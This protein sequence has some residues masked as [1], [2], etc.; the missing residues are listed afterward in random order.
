MLWNREKGYKGIIVL[1][2]IILLEGV[3]LWAGYHNRLGKAESI[4]ETIWSA[5]VGA[6]DG[7]IVLNEDQAGITQR[8]INQHEDL[9]TIYLF[10][11]HCQ[12][13]DSG[14]ITVKLRDAVNVTY[15]ETVFNLKDYE[16]DV[17]C[18]VMSPEEQ[19][20]FKINEEYFIEIY[21]KDLQGKYIEVGAVTDPSKPEVFD[22]FE[23]GTALF[24]GLEYNYPDLTDSRNWIHKG[25]IW[26]VILDGFLLGVELWNLGKKKYLVGYVLVLVCIG[27]HMQLESAR[28]WYRTNNYIAHA[29]GE[30]DGYEYTNSLEAFRQSY[31]NGHRVFEADFA[32]TSD[33][34]IVLKHDWTGNR[35]LPQFENGYIPTLDE[36]LDAKIWGEYTTMDL[37]S[38]F[39]LMLEY[40]DVYIVT[41]SKDDGYREV[42]E[43][44][45][46]INSVINEYDAKARKHIKEH[47]VV[48]IYN[49]DMYTAVEK[50]FDAKHYLY[51][52]YKRG[53]VNDLEG[54]LNFCVQNNI[55][56][57]T[58]PYRWWTAEVNE[59]IHSYDIEVWLHPLNSAEEI[60]SYMEQGVDG[61]YTDCYQKNALE[62]EVKSILKYID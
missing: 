54:I 24:V 51:T 44:F 39:D 1:F 26:C 32:M 22:C 15:Y 42:T 46:Q 58:M 41:D 3:F 21:A 43:E 17:F 25:I 49:N 38:L 40:T 23:D 55:P 52:L 53:G 14:E 4:N 8:F 34:E 19:T 11:Y 37:R 2:L 29:M 33:N 6:A 12:D 62:E 45:N 31:Q 57:I 59:Q 60:A 16:N 50:T 27:V 36:F 10:F 20:I 5:L 30:I 47:M 48:Q 35:G 56:V 9:R 28:Q 61:F 7:R 18:L 13:P